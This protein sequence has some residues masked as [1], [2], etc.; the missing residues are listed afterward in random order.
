[1]ATKLIPWRSTK[2]VIDWFDNI[3]GKNRQE[4]IELD[5]VAI[6][7][8]LLINAIK[9]AWL[10]SWFIFWRI[11]SP[12]VPSHFHMDIIPAQECLCRH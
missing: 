7:K 5:I 3:D 12:E 4:F 11:S 8:D 2:D 9:L 10:V 1:M 6:K